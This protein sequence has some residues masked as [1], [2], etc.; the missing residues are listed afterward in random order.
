METLLNS[1]ERQLLPP[2][3]VTSTTDSFRLKQFDFS[4]INRAWFAEHSYANASAVG[5]ALAPVSA[6]ATVS[7]FDFGPVPPAFSSP[8]QVEEQAAFGQPMDNDL[9]SVDMSRVSTD[10]CS[11]VSM[12]SCSTFPTSV[13]SSCGDEEHR[14]P[15]LSGMTALASPISLTGGGWESDISL[16]NT[17]SFDELDDGLR[18]KYE[19]RHAQFAFS[20]F[21]LDN[22]WPASAPATFESFQSADLSMSAGNDVGP[23]TISSTNDGQ[24]NFSPFSF[25]LDLD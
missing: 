11:S 12:S 20:S 22:P 6:P 1:L 2:T 8:Q 23:P 19:T 18:P 3:P 7:S 5:D 10:Y 4:G 16:L 24:A 14:D 17:D 9:T 21:D 25:S 13:S 15:L